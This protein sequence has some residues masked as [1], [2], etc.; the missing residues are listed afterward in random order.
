MPAKALLHHPPPPSSC[1][2]PF[3]CLNQ[4]SLA[5]AATK[6]MTLLLQ[7]VW[8]AWRCTDWANDILVPAATIF[9]A[10]F[11]LNAQH[12]LLFGSRA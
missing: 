3:H 8:A 9:V 10:C 1:A 7:G 2:R 11:I 6:K 5:P 4:T 12:V